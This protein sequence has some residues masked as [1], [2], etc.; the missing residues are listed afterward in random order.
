M[1]QNVDFL[2]KTPKTTRFARLLLGAQV[3]WR[4]DGQGGHPIVVI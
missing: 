3:V 1:L 2:M 4:L